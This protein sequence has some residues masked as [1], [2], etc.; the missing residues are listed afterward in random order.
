MASTREVTIPAT[1]QAA[2]KSAAR[3]R[4]HAPALPQPFPHGQILPHDP[5]LVLWQVA[6]GGEEDHR[7]TR[8]SYICDSCVTSARLIIDRRNQGAGAGES[9]RLP[10]LKPVEIKKRSTIT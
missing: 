6:G 3:I 9:A 7:P 4:R 2:C 10:L 8:G 1:V 5:V